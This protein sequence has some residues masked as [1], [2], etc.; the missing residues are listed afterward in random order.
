VVEVDLKRS[1]SRKR[2]LA[3]L[4]A[5]R[6][7]RNS[8]LVDFLEQTRPAEREGDYRAGDGADYDY[9]KAGDPSS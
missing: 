7:V 4:A 5:A 6:V 8:G 9:G 3:S 2:R 1:P